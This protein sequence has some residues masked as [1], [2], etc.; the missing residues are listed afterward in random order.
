MVR[1][2]N[3]YLLVEVVFE[4]PSPP[5]PSP[6]GYNQS[7]IFH[8]VRDSLQ[9]NFG[10]YGAGILATFGGKNLGAAERY[11]PLV[12]ARPRPNLQTSASSLP[13]GRPNGPLV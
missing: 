7:A 13:G 6:V 2:K 11:P 8:V 5:G 9:L 1:I 3:R 10:D 4:S 12:H